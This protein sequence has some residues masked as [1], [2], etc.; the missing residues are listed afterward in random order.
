MTG[1]AEIVYIDERVTRTMTTE[2]EEGLVGYIRQD[3]YEKDV[4]AA[5]A[6]ETEM[7]GQIIT[8]PDGR[9]VGL[10]TWGRVWAFVSETKEDLPAWILIADQLPAQELDS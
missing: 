5:R 2:P 4:R 10:S 8:N 7:I 6:R 9:L 1:A 3:L